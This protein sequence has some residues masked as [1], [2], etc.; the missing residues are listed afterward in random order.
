MR[1]IGVDV[2]GTNIKSLVLSETA[3]G[4][5]V[6]SASVRMTSGSS[7]EE[8]LGQVA[9]VVA[10]LAGTVPSVAAVGFSLPG[11]VDRLQGVSGVMPNLPGDWHERRVADAIASATGLRTVVVNDARAFTIAESRL[12][13]ARGLATVVGVTLGTG[14]GGG[15]V[16]DGRL[17]EGASGFAA[18]IG[19]QVIDINGAPCSCGSRGC[20]ETLVST[21]VILDRTGLSTVEEVFAAD[22][23]GD[24]RATAAI[25]DYV[26]CLAVALA[27]VHT[28]LC[29]DA[30]VVGG[31]IAAAGE[32]LLAPLTETMRQLTR[33]DRPANVHVRAAELGP[34]AGAVGA[35]LLA[36]DAADR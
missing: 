5:V 35:G 20:A 16:I 7:A 18:E 28:L 17:H 23:A 15:V 8:L 4:P 27:N 21:R 33:F 12:G 36:L 22:R 14:L 25:D 11:A 9:D 30:F 34:T 32:R 6:E 29:P 24:D 19:H 31:G 26:R 13:A 1:V 2:G 3:S 10:E